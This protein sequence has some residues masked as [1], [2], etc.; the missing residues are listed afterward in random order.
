M[1]RQICMLLCLFLATASSLA[2]K[3]GMA[4][5]QKYKHG[6]SYIYRIYLSDKKESPYSLTHPS[7]YLSHRSLD[8]RKRQHLKLD[9]TDLPVSPVISDR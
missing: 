3:P 2:T 6:I 4:Q 7:R 1:L 8:R 9:S 5:R